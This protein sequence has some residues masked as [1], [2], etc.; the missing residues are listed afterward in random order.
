MI[1][2]V[3]KIERYKDLL[4][5]QEQKYSE[6]GKGFTEAVKVLDSRIGEL[7]SKSSVRSNELNAR[8]K[9]LDE[10][11]SEKTFEVLEDEKIE[12]ELRELSI[13]LDLLKRQLSALGSGKRKTI[14]ANCRREIEKVTSA[15][16]E[17]AIHL[18]ILYQLY[19]KY[20]EALTA[21]EVRAK[22]MREDDNL[23]PKIYSAI[24]SVSV[25][26]SDL[27][28]TNAEYIFDTDIR[29]PGPN[30]EE[31][32]NPTAHG[33]VE[34]YYLTK[35]HPEAVAEANRTTGKL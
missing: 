27:L 33:V 12:G 18:Q 11:I 28:K 24:V 25:P 3:K 5:R 10:K 8:I 30:Y 32:L 20:F 6:A 16:K 9:M 17:L 21:L 22:K 4:D 7:K 29:E 23:Y 26:G 31:N 15:Y 35:I 1:E 19:N 2:L 34:S 14:T 13:E